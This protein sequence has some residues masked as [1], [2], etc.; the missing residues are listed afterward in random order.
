MNQNNDKKPVVRS[1]VMAPSPQKKSD[2]AYPDISISVKQ[3]ST[4]G[5]VLEAILEEMGRVGEDGEYVVSGQ[6]RREF[7]ASVFK[8]PKESWMRIFHYIVVVRVIN[9]VGGV[10]PL[11]EEFIPLQP[12]DDEPYMPIKK[13]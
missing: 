5:Q 6:A 7:I 2:V 11:D 4:V 3:G 9:G 8:M 10:V 13:G 12:V 1:T